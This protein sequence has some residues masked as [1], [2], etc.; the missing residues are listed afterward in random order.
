MCDV[1]AKNDHSSY[2]GE[3]ETLCLQNQKQILG[4]ELSQVLV[5]RLLC[6]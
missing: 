2:V 5:H 6:Q 1:V 4:S 3:D